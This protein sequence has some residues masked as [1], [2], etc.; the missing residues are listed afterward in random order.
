[1]LETMR[2]W[3]ALAVV[4]AAAGVVPPSASAATLRQHS[5]KAW[6]AYVAATEARIA[7]EVTSPRG[8]LVSDFSPDAADARTRMLRGE[9]VVSEM[10]A[11]AAG[12]RPLTVPDATVSHWRGGIFLPGVTL[13]AL[14]SR[15][16]N[17]PERAPF[18][19]DV[20]ALRVLERRPEMLKLFIRMTRTQIV[21]V[22]YDT[23]HEIAYRRRDAKRVW[24]RSVATKIAELDGVGTPGEREKSA[25]DDRGFLWRLNAYWRY[26]QVDGGVIVELE[27]LTL[28]RSAPFGLA[29]VVRPIID[30][31]ARES[32]NRTLVGIRDNF[33]RAATALAADQRKN[34]RAPAASSASESAP[35]TSPQNQ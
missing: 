7:G 34:R 17:P 9:I 16:R 15:L 6:D 3:R 4:M 8:F 21:T 19:Q 18:P 29:S 11:S 10:S 22:T 1:M 23:E 30:R 2:R 35:H 26:E 12:G 33:G 32:I 14:L 25:G 5:V 13:E 20:L 31:I 27:S 24:S 28:S